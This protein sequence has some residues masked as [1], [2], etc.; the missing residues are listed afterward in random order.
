MPLDT[1]VIKIFYNA[2]KALY[3]ARILHIYY[4]KLIENGLKKLIKNGFKH[5][6]NLK[7][8]LCHYK[9][10]YTKVVSVISITV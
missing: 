8:N 7:M 2:I 4:N 1:E 9:G 5:Y 10:C 3:T 6:Q